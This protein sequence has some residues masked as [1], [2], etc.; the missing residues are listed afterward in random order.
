MRHQRG[1]ALILVLMVL[2]LL[3]VG[4]GALFTYQETS[5]QL[6]GNLAERRRVFYVC[7]GVS[8]AATVLAQR[9]VLTANPT[10]P[11]MID[12]MCKEGA[13][14]TPQCCAT[15]FDTLT[16]A[17]NGGS[18][19][20]TDTDAVFTRLTY[21]PADDGTDSALDRLL[22]A[23]YRLVELAMGSPCRNVQDCRTVGPIP[24]GPF[25]GM[26]ARQDTVSFGLIAE[27]QATSKFR[28]S[29][30]QTITLGKIAM[31]QFFLFSDSAITD[32]HPGPPMRATGRMHANGDVHIAN[33][34]MLQRVTASGDL[35]VFV[36]PG[37]PCTGN[38]TSTAKVANVDNP[39][40]NNAANFSDFRRNDVSWRND[41]LSTYN[42]NAL[43][44]AHG[45]PRLQ[46]PILGS[47]QVQ[48]GRNMS[49]AVILNQNDSSGTALPNARLLIDPVRAAD[50]DDVRAQKFAEKADI[51]IINGVWYLNEPG[52][53]W[54]GTPIWS[55]HGVYTTN[56]GDDLV[57]GLHVGQTQLRVSRGWGSYTPRRFSYYRMGVGVHTL[58]YNDNA[59]AP[60]PAVVSYG[61]LFRS[62]TRPGES[63]HAPMWWPG[64]R[65][66]RAGAADSWCEAFP[67]G[68]NA[69]RHE[70]LDAL[71]VDGSTNASNP[72]ASGTPSNFTRGAALLAATRTGFRDGFAE[73]HLCGTRDRDDDNPACPNGD[74]R[75]ANVM[76]VN[77]DVSALQQALADPTTGE[78]GSY[79]CAK[80][81]G[82]M[83]RRRF[84]GI[85]WISNPYPG[86]A[87]TSS[88][89]GYGANGGA[90]TPANMPAP[91]NDDVNLLAGLPLVDGAGAND[92]TDWGSTKGTDTTAATPRAV[93][94]ILRDNPRQPN[95][96]Q[97]DRRDDEVSAL[98]F[99]LCSEDTSPA[100]TLGRS[101][102][103]MTTGEYRFRRPE[104]GNA[105]TPTTRL[106]GVRIINARVVN[107]REAVDTPPTAIVA[108]GNQFRPITLADTTRQLPD[109]TLPNGTV[110]S[111]AGMLSGDAAS[112]TSPGLSVVTNHPLFIVGDVNL[113]S[114]AFDTTLARHWVPVLFAGDTFHPLSNDWNDRK[115]RWAVSTSS[116]QL[117]TGEI[118]TNA[119]S[120]L[121]PIVLSSENG[122]SGS[123]RARFAKATRYHMQILSGWGLPVAGGVQTGIQ[124]YPF[125]MEYWSDG[126]TECFAASGGFTGGCPAVIYGS[127]VLGFYRVY[128]R[129]PF[130]DNS[131]L[132]RAPP[133][134]DWGFDPHL[135]DLARQPPGAPIFDVSAVKQW[136]RE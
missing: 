100:P 93:L 67:G 49:N 135:N 34:L 86:P 64:V 104:C 4:L 19:E 12:F 23:G 9:Y 117:R 113:T 50:T 98:P 136:S 123:Y 1:Y 8:R 128:T 30:Q 92:A 24:N 71:A 69:V 63:E 22:P 103:E 13:T 43:D 111:S 11:G 81:G 52:S 122:A 94:P 62:T 72:C 38:C 53:T 32:W 90:G 87:G 18:C 55:D 82:C 7:D 107:A 57:S 3:S 127:L 15:T 77:F 89:D 125:F 105:A 20:P 70:M 61:G 97:S 28:C 115:S 116:G 68:T 54:P 65:T 66:L 74:R 59:V 112:E 42:N 46:L 85:V 14:G 39:D 131:N 47:P 40:F 17:P 106:T 41:A 84:N 58:E 129:W 114:H 102:Q 78:L 99:P 16:G 109:I 80:G 56:L 79:F 27:H 110:V 29:T 36:N 118:A 37:A 33:N 6:T 132:T 45:V 51:R 101:G 130:F 126:G 121:E 76:P 120:A 108:E 83:M 35:R 2:A 73:A 5:G 31:F 25:A 26:N 60:V 48:R 96:R 119:T 95:A 124:N 88:E 75:E 133:R 134:R 10:T 91:I 21:N 44:R